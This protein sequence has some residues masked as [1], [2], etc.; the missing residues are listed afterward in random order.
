MTFEAKVSG[1]QR[2]D[3]VAPSKDGKGLFGVLGQ[4][5]DPAHQR[6]Y[7][8]KAAAAERPL[9]QSSNAVRQEAQSQTQAQNQHE[10]QRNQ[11]RSVG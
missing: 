6:V 8:D 11:A 5:N 10:Q 7:T 9:E 2:I 3:A 4:L 1:L